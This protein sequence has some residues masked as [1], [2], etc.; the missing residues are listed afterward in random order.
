[1]SR[2]LEAEKPYQADFKDNSIYFSREAKVDGCYKN[3]PYRFCLPVEC[4]SENL[5]S[6]FRDAA[7]AYFD[8]FQI[9]WH[10]GGHKRCSNHMCDSQV[11]CVNFLYPFADHPDALAA[12]LK[13]LFPDLKQ[14]L[15]IEAGQYVA[16]EWIGA[17]N[18]LGE[19][20]RSGLRSRGANFTS[21][22]AAVLFE[23]NDG[24]RQA[25]LIEWKY[26]ESYSPSPLHIAKSGKDRRTI[27][28]HLFNSADCPIDRDVLPSYDDL[29][30]EPFY[31][32]FRQ[33]LLAH[34]ME[35]AHELG[36]DLV[37]LLHISP[38]ANRDFRRV[39]SLGLQHLGS[40]ATAV[41]TQL[42]KPGDRFLSISTESL[43]NR[44]VI[45]QFPKMAPWWSYI[46][47]RYAWVEEQATGG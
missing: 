40:T 4:A 37:S 1:M 25:V 39:T 19:I 31:Q 6:G 9:K 11:C 42:V 30:Y 41:W 47:A 12:M 28:Q 23:R 22:D 32:L 36:T 2:F 33:Q 5:Y 16:F 44:K 24:K 14:M 45:S 15:P 38:A 27:Y 18:Y 13:P 3:H 8:Q 7:L 21:A 17:N 29:F 20:S 46:S 35:K 10:D 34:E 43:F 26:T